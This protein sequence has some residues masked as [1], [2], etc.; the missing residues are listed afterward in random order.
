MV[1]PREPNDLL[2]NGNSEGLRRDYTPAPQITKAYL[3]GCLHDATIRRTTYRISTKNLSYAK[4][5]QSGLKNLN[6][7]AWIYKEG[8][9]EIYG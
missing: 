2:T 4:V 1:I 7:N 6:A 3:L 8:N 9:L 5:L